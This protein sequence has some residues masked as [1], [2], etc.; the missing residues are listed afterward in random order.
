M[1]ILDDG[2]N[3]LVSIALNLGHLDVPLPDGA[4]AGEGQVDGGLV[5]AGTAN[6]QVD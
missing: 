5:G 4:G 1:F 3:V 6:V 2:K